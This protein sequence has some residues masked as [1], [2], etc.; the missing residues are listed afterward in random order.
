MNGN[1]S[2]SDQSSVSIELW[3][4]SVTLAELEQASAVIDEFTRESTEPQVLTPER[5]ARA[6]VLQMLCSDAGVV[7]KL[8]ARADARSATLV[9]GMQ[10]DGDGQNS[11]ID[12][13]S[14]WLMRRQAIG[15]GLKTCVLLLSGSLRQDINVMVESFMRTTTEQQNIFFSI[16]FGRRRERP[17][18][19]PPPASF[20]SSV[21]PAS[22]N[23]T[24]NQGPE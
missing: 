17:I 19:A 5:F 24:R 1:A 14:S 3:W 13:F 21:S 8:I 11:G 2:S 18:T 20:R 9:R 23:S 15:T 22:G 6:L 10:L 16:I 12:A 4:Q 7:D